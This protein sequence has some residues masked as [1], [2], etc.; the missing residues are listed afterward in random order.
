MAFPL[1]DAAANRRS[2]LGLVGLGALAAA[3]GGALAGCG[4]KAVTQGATT[5][6]ERINAIMPSFSDINIP[7][8]PQPD[9]KGTPPFSDAYLKYPSNVAE[10]VKDVPGKSGQAIKAM[11]PVWGSAPPG[12]GSNGY[13]DVIN[14]KLG[15]TVEF[16]VQDGNT[17]AD[18][19]NAMLAARDVPDLLCVPS[20]EY[21]KVPKFTE[22]AK[23]LF[24]DL[25]PFLQGDAVKNYAML[26]TFPTDQW[27]SAVWA[28]RLYSV[29]N[30]GGAGFPW[31]LFYRKDLLD[32]KGLTYPKTIDDLYRVLKEVTNPDQG[33]WGGNDFFAMVQMF[34]KVPGSRGGWRVK[35]N[36]TVEHKF[37]TQEY[38]AAMEF[39][40]K[41]YTE[42]LVHPDLVATKGGQ[43]KQLFAGGQIVFM[44]DGPGVWGNMQSEQQK[45]LPTFK[46]APVPVFSATGGD[47]L[48]WIS[49]D[50]ISYTFIKKGLGKERVEELLRVINWCSAPY[51]TKEWEMREFGGEGTH[52]TRDASGPVLTD[53]GRKEIANQYFFIS[54]R[55]P[56]GSPRADLP[57]HLETTMAYESAMAKFVEKD[58]WAGIK[59]E[60]PARYSQIS[61]QQ[62][63]DKITDVLR[64]R[65]PMSDVDQIVKEFRDGGGDEAR[66]LLRKA[67][68]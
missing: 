45:I 34:Y 25:T 31:M 30:P 36:G 43:G 11:T 7:G 20:W 61:G 40:A 47:P 9:L 21:P 22:A 56:I 10:V 12:L 19:L 8:M 66:E 42:G 59:I 49:N 38:R 65:R 50:P 52:F 18:K 35:S 16:S 29:P 46:M 54:G 1:E 37:E 6:A 27:R 28:E 58:P 17:Y 51:G 14:K 60:W 68:S 57:G 2:F 13:Y 67:L 3:S 4:D 53:L 32:A 26:A 55:R 44:Q 23:A 41:L 33:V 39:T 15:I 5:S 63:E 64:G 62:T 24:E 48:V